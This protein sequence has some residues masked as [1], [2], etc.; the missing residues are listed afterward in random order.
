MRVRTDGDWEG[1]IKF[2]LRG[3]YEVSLA[4]ARTG[5]EIVQMRESHRDLVQNKCRGAKNSL[6]LLETLY[7]QPIISAKAAVHRLGIT[8]VTVRSLIN[9]LEALGLLEEI[10]G[11]SRDRLYKYAPY[12]ALF[13]DDEAAT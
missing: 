6:R 1:W 7:Q 9:Q 11:R 13:E 5:R 4:S 12:L 3:V 8:D 10:T 2:F